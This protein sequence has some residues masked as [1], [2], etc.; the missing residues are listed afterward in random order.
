MTELSTNALE[1]KRGLNQRCLRFRSLK[2]TVEVYLKKE[3]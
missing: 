3:S 1:G 2:G